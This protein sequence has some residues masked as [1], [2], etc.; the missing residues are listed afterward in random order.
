MIYLLQKTT[1]RRYENENQI[2]YMMDVE[3]SLDEILNHDSQ[4]E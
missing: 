3:S 2:F 1:L 4:W